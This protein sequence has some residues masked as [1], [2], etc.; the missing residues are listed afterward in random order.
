MRCG[1]ISHHAPVAIVCPR[2][3]VA[4]LGLLGGI[5]RITNMWFKK[6]SSRPTAED[7]ARRLIILKH[8]IAPPRDMLRQMTAEWSANE[9][10]KFSRQA[11]TQ[12]EQFWRGVRDAGLW[13]HLSPREQAHAQRTLV[14]M[15]QQQQA[16][17]SWRME[18]A[19]TLM[20]VLACC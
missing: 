17:A 12:R 19:Q 16:D 14:T 13:Q 8:V 6:R 7:V 20:W 1:E 5:T 9:S 3:R 18:A 4:E 10:E 2:G 15:T 11:E